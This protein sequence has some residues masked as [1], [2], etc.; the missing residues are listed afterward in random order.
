LI[1]SSKGT[2]PKIKTRNSQHLSVALD[3]HAHGA[4]SYYQAQHAKHGHRRTG[5]VLLT[6]VAE[7]LK[8]LSK[9]IS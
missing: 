2:G 9:E 1:D 3:G 8:S 7:E 4:P 6:L 5:F